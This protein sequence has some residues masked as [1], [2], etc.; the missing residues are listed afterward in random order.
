M[1]MFQQDKMTILLKIN[2]YLLYAIVFS[3]VFSK[4]NLNSFVI[5]LFFLSWLLEGRYK[6]KW[7]KLRTDKIFI[8]YSMYFILQVFGLFY[9][10][11][12]LTGWKHVE[13]KAGFLVLPLILCSNRFLYNEIKT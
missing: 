13:S 10:S 8:A 3:I 1:F 6:Q 4:L 5:I 12:L 7:Q 2:L 11:D 9:T